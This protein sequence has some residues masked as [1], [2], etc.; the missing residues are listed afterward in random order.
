MGIDSIAFAAG[1]APLLRRMRL[2]VAVRMGEM[3]PPQLARQLATIDQMLGGRLA[4]N[5]ISSGSAR[6]G[7]G[8]RAQ[9]PSHAGNTCAS[10]ATCWT[11]S[12]VDVHGDYIDA[13]LDPPRLRPASGR[14][15][16]FYFGG[17]SEAA[18]E[19]AAQAADVY[20]MWPDTMPAVEAMSPTCGRALP[21]MAASSGSATARMSS[22]APP[23][24][25]HGPPH[26]G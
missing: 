5:I 6:A 15:P 11:A 7:A 13:A 4:V 26:S 1:I 16:P 14:C 19:V 9:I 20:L 12:R 22:S 8:V 3:W 18:R 10:C 25:K 24:K 2:L 17:L 21:A 23:S